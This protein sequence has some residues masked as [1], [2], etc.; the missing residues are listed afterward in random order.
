MYSEMAQEN[1]A[2]SLWDVYAALLCHQSLILAMN[3]SS[4]D[5][6][7]Q[8]ETQLEIVKSSFKM[9]FNLPSFEGGMYWTTDEEDVDDLEVLYKSILS[10]F[11]DT[12]LI[13]VS[14]D[15]YKLQILKEMTVWMSEDKSYLQE[16]VLVIIKRVLRF[17]SKKAMEYISVDAP[18]VGIL[19]AELSLSYSHGDF[20]IVHQAALAMYYL[21]SIAK[22]QMVKIL[23]QI[24]LPSMLTDFVLHLLTKLSTSDQDTTIRAAVILK[25]TLKCHAQKIT[26][27]SQMVNTIH[28]Q[29]N[30]NPSYFV[31][32]VLLE[33]VTLLTQ[34]SPKGV[35]FQLVDYP[36]PADRALM[37]MWQAVGIKP[38]VAPQVLKA[39]LL[40]L[41]DKPW[42]VVDSLQEEKY[43]V[44]DTTNMM[45]LAAS[46]ALCI[47][48]PIKSY[49]QTVAQ[50]FPELLVALM[51]Q[52]LHIHQL[53]VQT[54]DRPLYAQEALRLLLNCSGLQKVDITLKKSFYWSQASLTY[55]Y[56][57]GV[58]LIV[59]TLC[60]YNFP[61]FL[62]T[63]YY[64]HKVLVQGPRRPEEH[65]IIVIFFIKILDKFFKDPLPELFLIFLRNWI[66]D[67]NPEISILSL[68]K[69]TSMAPVINKIEN[70]SILLTSIV[71]AFVSKDKTV[72]LQALLTLRRLIEKLDKVTYSSLCPGIASSYFRLMDHFYG[73]IRNLAIRHLAALLKD[74]SHQTSTLKHILGGFTPLILCLEDRDGTV[75]SACKYALAICDSQLEWSI[76]NL[77]KDEDYNFEVVV[78]HICNRL[79]LSHGAGITS[80]VCDTLKF[81]GSSQ[82]HLRRAAV[83]LLG[84][85]AQLGGHLLFKNEIE[86]MAEAIERMLLDEDH[87]IQKLAKITHEVLKQIASRSRSTAIKLAIQRFFKFTYS[88]ELKL[89]YNWNNMQLTVDETEDQQSLLSSVASDY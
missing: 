2:K 80:L 75:V 64:L 47:L 67:S 12:L 56:Y 24:L 89:L 85:L 34:I 74:T 26:R 53:R 88:K 55:A 59:R 17:A 57:E 33:V 21:L 9:V 29:L 5:P 23:G 16:R 52:L 40:V 70:V 84:Y 1:L 7:P 15:L 45:P 65:I 20:A 50:F 28:K 63:L 60:D 39:I 14:K 10:L 35:I 11:E 37:M 43:F 48:L 13:L 36:V 22:R 25:L 49:K 54:K 6:L 71:N 62:E 66:S 27:V 69:I 86:V 87:M 31:K 46:Q 42:E 19:A 58:H 30:G 51:L 3:S 18:C 83:I 38:Q 32:D 41:K 78:F 73:N 72:V 4:V 76:S 79:L 8:Y 44:L 82:V 61:Q 77:L 68:Q 81:L